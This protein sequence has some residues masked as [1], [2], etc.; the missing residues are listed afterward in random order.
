MPGAPY[1][2]LENFHD[3]KLTFFSRFNFG[4]IKIKCKPVLLMTR[5]G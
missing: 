5:F 2:N 3:C 1:A 4:V